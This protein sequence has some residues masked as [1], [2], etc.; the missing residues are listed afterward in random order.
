MYVYKNV[1][2]LNGLGIVQNDFKFEG[3]MESDF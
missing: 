3:F 2:N 1:P